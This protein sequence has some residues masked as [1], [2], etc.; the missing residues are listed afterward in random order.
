MTRQLLDN[1]Q[2]Q[3]CLNFS[4]LG[5]RQPC[6]QAAV[7]PCQTHVHPGRKLLGI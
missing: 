7:S 5:A 4:V 1:G 3:K 2:R 6:V